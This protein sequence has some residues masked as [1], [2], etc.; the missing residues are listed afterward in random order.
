[1]ILNEL[2]DNTSFDISVTAWYEE[3]EGG[4]STPMV[5]F[6]IGDHY[7]KTTQYMSDAYEIKGGLNKFFNE[8]KKE[9]TK[10]IK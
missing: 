2:W 3:E 6:E 8:L 1:M 7:K 5:Q 4:T 10:R 9:I